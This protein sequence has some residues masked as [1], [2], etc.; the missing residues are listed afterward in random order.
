VSGSRFYIPVL[1][2]VEASVDP[3]LEGVLLYVPR[4]NQES[5]LI[6]GAGIAWPTLAYWLTT[7]P[8]QQAGVLQLALLIR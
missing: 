7:D 5:V 4:M 8:M 1:R 6:S 3:C 2:A